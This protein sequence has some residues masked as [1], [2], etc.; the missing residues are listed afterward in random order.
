MRRAGAASVARLYHQAPPRAGL[1]PHEVRPGA[2]A[3]GRRKRPRWGVGGYRSRLS[4]E[5]VP[6][7]FRGRHVVLEDNSKRRSFRLC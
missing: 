1:A 2:P 7:R 4:G 3:T 5:L 6:C